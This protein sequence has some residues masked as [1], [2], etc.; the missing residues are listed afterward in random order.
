MK[1]TIDTNVFAHLDNTACDYNS[2]AINLIEELL[3]SAH[4]MCLDEGYDPEPGKNRSLI[5]QENYEHAGGHGSKAYAALLF[6]ST[7]Q[8]IYELPKSVVSKNKPKFKKMIKDKRDRV[9]LA[10]AF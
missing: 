8:R 5:W 2:S 7:K 4:I 6:L 1:L 9:F 10:V 3:E